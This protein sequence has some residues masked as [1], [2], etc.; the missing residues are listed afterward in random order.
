MINEGHK[1]LLGL[2]PEFE[3]EIKGN[4]LEIKSVKNSIV[5]LIE[6]NVKALSQVQEL[7]NEE[8]P[9]KMQKLVA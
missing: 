6:A 5:E 4:T 1:D 9:F 3:D 7:K 8:M 2:A